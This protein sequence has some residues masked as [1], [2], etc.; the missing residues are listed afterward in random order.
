MATALLGLAAAV[1][2]QAVMAG[3]MHAYDARQRFYSTLSG[4]E[5]MER[6]LALPYTDPDGASAPGPEAGEVGPAGFD[7]ID[8]FHG[9]AESAGT[10]QSGG[11]LTVPPDWDLF[12]RSVTVA[13]ISITV[14]SFSSP[15]D[16]AA[17]TVEMLDAWNEQ[18]TLG[19]FVA[20]PQ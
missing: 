9:Y 10:T 2:G 8:D 20:Q 6:I 13:Y 19:R 11:A 7:N 4:E 16:G 12:D 15:V 5:F 1:L 17:I 14:P 18:W 3:Q